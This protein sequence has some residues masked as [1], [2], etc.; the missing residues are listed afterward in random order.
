[1]HYY[2]PDFHGS[3]SLKA[4]LP[5]LVPEVGYQDLEIQEGG[6]ASLA[7]EQMVASETAE[8]EKARIREALLAYC[9]RDTEAMVRIFDALR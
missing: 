7:F 1:M 2:H 4:V 6:H 8:H 3:H 5:V 9:H